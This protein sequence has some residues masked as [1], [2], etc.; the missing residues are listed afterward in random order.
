MRAKSAKDFRLKVQIPKEEVEQIWLVNW[1]RKRYPHL[2]FSASA[3]GG[4]R[5]IAEAVKFKRMGVSKGFPDIEIPVARKSYHG[6]YIELKRQE[7]GVLKKEQKEWLAFLSAEGN[8]AVRCD[9]FKEAANL[10]E[11]YL[12]DWKPK[13]IFKEDDFDDSEPLPSF[14]GLQGGCK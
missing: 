11:D 7:G 3:N 9:G 4:S 12:G 8:L 13:I 10:I 6:L 5:H 2:K 14:T 1:L